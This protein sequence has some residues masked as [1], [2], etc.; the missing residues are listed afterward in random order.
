LVGRGC[1]LLERQSVLVFGG[2]FKRW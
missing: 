1:N 2:C